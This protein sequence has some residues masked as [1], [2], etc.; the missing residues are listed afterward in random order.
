MRFIV[1]NNN[2]L[3]KYLLQVSVWH[4]S[5]GTK[6]GGTAPTSTSP[7]RLTLPVLLFRHEQNLCCRSRRYK[8]I[9]RHVLLN[10]ICLE[11]WKF[12][13]IFSR[14]STSGCSGLSTSSA[15]QATTHTGTSWTSYFFTDY[16][17]CSKS[18]EESCVISCSH[19]SWYW[20][21]CRHQCH[22]AIVR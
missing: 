10:V 22:T 4:V 15:S 6:S 1:C 3:N 19:S 21:C 14:F 17:L 11:K 2:N 5:R 8:H 16:Q 9:L 18:L 12:S 13:F 7:Q 20:S